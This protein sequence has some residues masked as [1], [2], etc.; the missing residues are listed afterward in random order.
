MF[1]SLCQLTGIDFKIFISKIPHILYPMWSGRVSSLQPNT[2]WD[3][4]RG[5][6]DYVEDMY[7]RG[8]EL[9]T[10]PIL[11][12]AMSC[13]S[14][15]MFFRPTIWHRQHLVDFTISSKMPSHQDARLMSKSTGFLDLIKCS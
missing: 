11:T 4:V 12:M 10:A 7:D 5:L 3:G 15:E 1:H 14:C 6:W 9:I 2:R 8:R 13:L